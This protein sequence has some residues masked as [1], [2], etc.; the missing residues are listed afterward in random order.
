ML[1]NVDHCFIEKNARVKENLQDHSLQIEVIVKQYWKKKKKKRLLV[2]IYKE[3]HVV[4]D[5]L[6]A[7]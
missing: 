7:F 1:V 4:K 6:K 3:K 2:V 5:Q